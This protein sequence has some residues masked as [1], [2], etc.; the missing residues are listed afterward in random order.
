VQRRQ[1]LQE[2]GRGHR[3]L[4]AERHYRRIHHSG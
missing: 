1:H 4:P 3:R 2:L